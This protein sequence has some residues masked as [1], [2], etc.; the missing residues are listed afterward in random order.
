MFTPERAPSDSRLLSLIAQRDLRSL[1]QF[2]D[3]H[4][5]VV[6][7][8]ILYIV[9]DKALADELLQ[10]TFL[11]VWATAGSVESER[12]AVLWLYQLA[13]RRCLDALRW[14]LQD[15]QKQ[16]ALTERIR[17]H[18]QMLSRDNGSIGSPAT[19]L[20]DFTDSR[21]QSQR[22]LTWRAFQMMPEEQRACLS[23]AFFAGMTDQE[24]ANYIHFPLPR[25]RT[26][27]SDGVNR[28]GSAAQ[29]APEE[30]KERV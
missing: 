21:T 15:A 9:Q 5:E 11:Q 27:I 20:F 7:G 22:D 23:L 10:E 13:R 3:R 26:F 18:A 29:A 28:L 2:Y 25:I 12:D 6:Y 24:I 19:V 1:E 16:M 8:L 17:E 4:A 30:R 14:S